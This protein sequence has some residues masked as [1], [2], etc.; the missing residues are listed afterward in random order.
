MPQC[1]MPPSHSSKGMVWLEQ[2]AGRKKK[3]LQHSESTPQRVGFRALQPR[4]S[5]PLPAAPSHTAA[6]PRAASSSIAKKE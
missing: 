4:Y 5:S 3:M 2:Q 6:L 1:A